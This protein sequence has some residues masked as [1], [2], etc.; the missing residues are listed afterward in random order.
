MCVGGGDSDI[1]YIH[2]LCRFFGGRNFQFQYFAAFK[3]NNYFFLGWKLLW[4]CFG[5]Y[6]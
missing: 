4:I 3:K 5:G 1:F 2:R 6:F